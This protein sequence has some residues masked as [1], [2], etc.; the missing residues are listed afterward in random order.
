MTGALAL[1]VP[2]KDQAH[3]LARLHDRA[4]A[5]QSRAWQ[6]SEFAAL[7]DSEHVFAMGEPRAFALGRVIADEAELL[8]L[9]TD[10][11]SRRQ[12]L[13]R[14]CLAAFED[15]AR[16]RG[17]VQ[18]FL[19]VAETNGA[20]VALYLAAGYQQ[21]ARREGYYRLDDGRRADALI[22]TKKL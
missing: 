11:A 6:A 1:L 22:L 18:A 16:R 21:S 13:G 12:G 20:A 4:F 14:A 3:A 2:G 19:E 9:A 17:A 8:T 15:E 10:P 5:G 7:L